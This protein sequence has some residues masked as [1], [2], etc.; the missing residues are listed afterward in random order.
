MLASNKVNSLSLPVS[1]RNELLNGLVLSSYIKY[2]VT[3]KGFLLND[4]GFVHSGNTSHVFLD[5]FV[6]T[7]KLLRYKKKLVPLKRSLKEVNSNLLSYKKRLSSLLKFR[8][9]K[10]NIPSNTVLRVNY[11]NYQV[12]DSKRMSDIYTHF[13]NQQRLMFS[14]RVNLF[15]DF[16][17]AVYLLKN[18]A[19]GV[20][21]FLVIL[22]EVFRRLTKRKH[23]RFIAFVRVLSQYLVNSGVLKGLKFAISGRLMGKPRA[24]TAKVLFGSLEANSVSS[25]C[26]YAQID[27]YTFDGAFGLKLWINY[28]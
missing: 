1:T 18:K 27:V 21:L 26:Q 19:V 9:S 10:V 8:V 17:K 7:S 12:K 14:R 6:Q 23:S 4:S 2:A 3:K 22:G 25:N 11:L 13:K 24:S 15:A 20:N 28:K 16:L 5:L